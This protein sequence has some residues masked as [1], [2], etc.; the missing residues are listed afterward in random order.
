MAAPVVIGSSP[1]A[2]SGTGIPRPGMVRLE[3]SRGSTLTMILNAPPD[4]GGGIGGWQSSE[5]A[6]RRPAKWWQATPDDTMSLDC[7]IDLHAIGGPSVERRIQALREMG[8]PGDEDEPPSITITGDI[9]Q[10]DQ[11]INWVMQDC[12]LGARLFTPDGMLRRQQVTI[13]LERYTPVDLIEPIRA[14]GARAAGGK[15]RNR[16]IRTRQGDTV[17]AI[18]LRELSD[19]TRW[20]DLRKWN[21]PL[22]AIDPDMTLRTGTRIQIKA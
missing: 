14:R 6:L 10:P 20:R 16:A 21:K 1:Q 18:A 9:W 12:K 13:D 17:R 22:R 5:R 8:Q 3:P 2:T 15:R 7:T 4:R 11:A 19:A